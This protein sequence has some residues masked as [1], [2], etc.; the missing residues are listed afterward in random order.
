M[1]SRADRLTCDRLSSLARW[2]RSRDARS[3]SRACSCGRCVPVRPCRHRCAPAA[4]GEPRYKETRHCRDCRPPYADQTLDS[5]LLHR[6]DEH[7]GRLREKP[8][9]LEDDFGPNRNTK[10]LD[11]GIDA[12]QRAFHRS[13]LERV[14]GNFIEFGV[15]DGY[16]SGRARQGTNRM[17]RFEGGL[18]G[19]LDSCSRCRRRR[20][21]SSRPVRGCVAGVPCLTLWTCRMAFSRSTRPPQSASRPRAGS[22]ARGTDRRHWACAPAILR[23]V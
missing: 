5:S 23:T 21:R 19:D 3:P 12:G 4:D 9:R 16:S 1:S 14:A 17:S 7:L 6:G 8:R 22:G 15:I 2:S 18:H 13:H 20:A 10:R 11:D